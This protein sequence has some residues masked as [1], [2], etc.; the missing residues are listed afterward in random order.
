MTKILMLGWEFPP[1]FSGGLGI[2]T[3]GLVKALSPKTDIRLIIPQA[4]A[5]DLSNV[6]IIGLNQLTAQEI[7]LERV[8]FNFSF[9]N[10]KVHQLSVSISPYHYANQLIEDSQ[11]NAFDA[12]STDQKSIDQI[13]NIFSGKEVYGSNV[14]HKVYLFS[15]LSE[16]IAADGNFN[17]IHAHDWVTYPAGIN[18]KHRTH[19]PLVL[20]VHALETDRVG[21]HARNEI[22]KVER[23][24]MEEADKVIAVS[25][26]TRQQIMEHYQ[27]DEHKIE[28]VHNGIDPAGIVRTQHKLKDKLVVFLGRLTHQK[29]PQYLVETAEKV[30]QVYPRVKFIVAGMGDQF[31]PLLE[32]SAYKKL[33]H[34][35]IFAGFLSKA[36]VNELLA[37]ADVYF[38][39]SVSEPFGL[40]A[41]EAA[42]HFVPSVISSQSGAAEVMKS[43]LKADH[44][45]TDKYANYIHALLRYN[46]LHQNL[47]LGANH[48][49]QHV[50]WEHAAEKVC[51]IYN[52]L[53]RN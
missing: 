51:G 25:H 26:Y 42:Q 21:G 28:V 29:G 16:E 38:M 7:D 6:N 37:L 24:G 2:A 8:A 18:I 33:G 41:L 9:L 39:P 4:S 14:M 15:K 50:T 34:H 46:A 27:I 48:E 11:R 32:S 31:A 35:F 53:Y 36:K 22:Y 30:A 43:S 45:D 13:N 10:A 23:R 40:T 3:Y 5:N 19:K 52:Q 49:I 1:L 47:S 12:L 17:V 20:H 44:W